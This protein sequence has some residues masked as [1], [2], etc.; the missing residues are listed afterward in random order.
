MD[1]LHPG[2][3]GDGHG[4]DLAGSRGLDGP[5]KSRRCNDRPGRIPDSGGDG[6]DPGA[7]RNLAAVE[8]DG[9]GLGRGD[10]RDLVWGLDVADS[11][12][13]GINNSR[14]GDMT[15]LVGDGDGLGGID[16]G[17]R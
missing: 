3:R 16:G 1:D 17:G 6:L 13:D 4:L 11:R 14:S 12:A 9:R 2:S 10:G 15:P 8:G 7:G 5:I